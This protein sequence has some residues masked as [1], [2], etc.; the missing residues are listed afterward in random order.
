[1]L[2]SNLLDESHRRVT[3]TLAK[4]SKKT[5]GADANGRGQFLYG[6]GP[7]P[8]CRNVFLGEPH[9]PGCRG[10]RVAVQELAVVVT[11]SE[12]KGNQNQLFELGQQKTTCLHIR[13]IQLGDQEQDHA[14]QLLLMRV[15][16]IDFWI[17][18]ARAWTIVAVV[19]IG[20]TCGSCGFMTPGQGILLRDSRVMAPSGSPRVRIAVLLAM[21]SVLICAPAAA[22]VRIIASPGGRIGPFVDLFERVRETGQRVVIDG[23]CLSACTLVLSLVPYDRICVTGRAVLGFHAARSADARGRLRSKP[24]ATDLVLSVYP[25]P[26]RDWIVRHGGLTS[27]VIYL[28]GRELAALYPTCR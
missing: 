18:Y 28:R 4:G 12:Q 5:A 13:S 7:V 16:S 3:A 9:L 14:S 25:E 6:N 8:V 20:T 17:E 26:V 27:R 11:V 23:P 19:P 1:M 22:D 10:L 2:Q 24:E 21:L 15:V